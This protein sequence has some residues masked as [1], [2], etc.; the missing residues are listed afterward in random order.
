MKCWTCH[1][2]LILLWGGVICIK[3]NNG[4]ASSHQIFRLLIPLRVGGY[5]K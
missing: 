1:G 5:Q 2:L 3:Q 4:L